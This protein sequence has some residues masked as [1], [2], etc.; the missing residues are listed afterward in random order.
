M[1]IA[2]PRVSESFLTRLSRSFFY[3][4]AAHSQDYLNLKKYDVSYA[5]NIDTHFNSELLLSHKAFLS[6]GN[7]EYGSKNLR[8]NIETARNNGVSVGFFGSNTCYWQIR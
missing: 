8:L 6:V 3:N 5:T 1:E 2:P 4:S 7:D